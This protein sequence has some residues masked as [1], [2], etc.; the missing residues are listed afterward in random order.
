MPL[1]NKKLNRFA[2]QEPAPVKIIRGVAAMYRTVQATGIG[3]PV[4]IA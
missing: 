4:D 1:I 2:E 3:Y